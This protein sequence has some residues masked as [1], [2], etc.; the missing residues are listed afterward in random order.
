MRRLTVCVFAFL[1]V[2]NFAFGQTDHSVV[3]KI[4]LAETT[5]MGLQANSPICLALLPARSISPTGA[6]PSPQLLRF[7]MRSGM[8][9][10][11]AST[12]YTPPPKGN[13]ISMELIK[14][15]ANRLSAKVVFKNV[16]LG[17]GRDLAIVHRRGV[18]ELIRTERSGW[19][20]Q[21]YANELPR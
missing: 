6:D 13:V 10:R 3:R 18:Y 14:E 20:I 15:G 5:A 19:V 1:T 21:S 11:K 7:L 2:C 4:V 12:C 16:T 17:P 8:R 9:P